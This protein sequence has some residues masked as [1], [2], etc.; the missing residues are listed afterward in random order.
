[1][2]YSLLRL[3]PALPFYEPRPGQFQAIN[4]YRYLKYKASYFEK[5]RRNDCGPYSEGAGFEILPGC[6][7]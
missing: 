3:S 6:L 2:S 1:M 4:C 5:L 7:S